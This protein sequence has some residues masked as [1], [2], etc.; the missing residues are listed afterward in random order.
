MA[1][2]NITN[3]LNSK[4]K[5]KTKNDPSEAEKISVAESNADGAKCEASGES[6]K[7]KKKGGI[8]SKFKNAVKRPLRKKHS[9]DLQENGKSTL[10]TKSTSDLADAQEE[11]SNATQEHGSKTKVLFLPYK[12][13]IMHKRSRAGHVTYKK[14]FPLTQIVCLYFSCTFEMFFI[15]NIEVSLCI[16]LRT[17][18]VF[19]SV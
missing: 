9:S 12:N 2:S 7:A 13:M 1:N 6:Q 18:N 17:D 15:R 4:L 10:R 11:E 3:E 5:A 8:F 19:N 16:V 14:D